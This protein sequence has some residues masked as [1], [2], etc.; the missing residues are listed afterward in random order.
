MIYFIQD[1]ATLNIKIGFTKGC[2]QARLESLQTGNPSELVLLAILDGE[3]PQE[4]D[5]HDWFKEYRIAG[6][7]FRPGSEIIR[8]MVEWA[9]CGCVREPVYDYAT[10]AFIDVHNEK[11][12]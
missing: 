3:R 9:R 1:T 10:G 4:A 6:E 7:W 12:Q 2:P 8:F 5:L 11:K